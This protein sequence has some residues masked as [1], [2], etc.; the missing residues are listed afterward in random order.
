MRSSPPCT[1]ECHWRLLPAELPSWQRD[2][3]WFRE[4]QLGGTWARLHEA[5]REL[6]AR[7]G[8][9]ALAAQR[10]HLGSSVGQDHR[11]GR[12]TRRRRSQEALWG[13]RHILVDTP[14]LALWALVPPADLQDRTAVP[15]GLGGE[16]TE[17]PRPAHAWVDQGPPAPAASCWSRSWL[18]VDPGQFHLE[19]I[20]QDGVALAP[21]EHEELRPTNPRDD[22]LLGWSQINRE[23][24]EGRTHGMFLLQQQDAPSGPCLSW[25]VSTHS[26]G[27]RWSPTLATIHRDYL[28]DVLDEL[29]PEDLAGIV[30]TGARGSAMEQV[31]EVLA[32]EDPAL[33]AGARSRHGRCDVLPNPWASS[34]AKPLGS[35]RW[36]RS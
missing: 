7:G 2:S 30:P 11:G 36:T 22:S 17:C 9:T 13:N 15:A 32:Y 27:S 12:A 6:A 28:A 10:W 35:R 19:G 23:R 5:L 1:P 33:L 25:H 26:N 8:R 34:K 16:V 31:M 18:F 21:Q 4:W 14:G 3:R 24:P 29:A 20:G